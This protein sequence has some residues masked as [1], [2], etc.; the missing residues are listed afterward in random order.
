[1]GKK[2]KGLTPVVDRSSRILILGSFPG[3]LSLKKR[4]Y[5][6]HPWNQFWNMIFGIFGTEVPASYRA[7]IKG[8]KANRIAL[9]DVIASCHRRNAS[10]SNICEPVFNDIAGLLRCYPGI[11][12][13]YCNGAK[14]YSVYRSRYKTIDLPVTYLP[15]TSPAHASYTFARKK[16]SWRKI[17][18]YGLFNI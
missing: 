13:I 6:A 17:I 2:L 5:Y 8:L 14:S 9:W 16:K 7:K 10:D 18:Q 3:P 12:A 4:Q 11:R 1:M 15:S